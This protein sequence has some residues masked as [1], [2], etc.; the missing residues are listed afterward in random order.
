MNNS[1]MNAIWNATGST[2]TGYDNGLPFIGKISSVRT[3][4]GVDLRVMV[5]LTEDCGRAAAGETLGFLGSELCA[6]EGGHSRNLHVY[7]DQ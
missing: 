6:G 5:T 1:F 2:V 4:A 7:F 3:M